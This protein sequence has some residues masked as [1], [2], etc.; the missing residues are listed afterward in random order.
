MKTLCSC[1]RSQQRVNTFGSEHLASQVTTHEYLV[2]IVQYLHYLH[3]HTY[4]L[5]LADILMPSSSDP[6]LGMLHSVLMCY[7]TYFGSPAS[8]IKSVALTIMSQEKEKL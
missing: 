1:H 2:K 8:L 4:T 3:T 6:M 5:S 7:V